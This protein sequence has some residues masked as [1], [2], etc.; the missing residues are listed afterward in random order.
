MVKKEL[1]AQ[2][3][4]DFDKFKDKILG[5]LLFGSVIT[6]T[7]TERSDV[8]VCVVVGRKNVKE[9]FD[10]LLESG[11]TGKYDIK[12]F[13]SLSLKIKGEILEN[14]VVVWAKDKGELSY[15]LHKYRKIWED[16]KLALKKIGLEIFT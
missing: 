9:I 3:N 7:E 2:I 15:Y 16:Q 4:R 1:M 8:D 10:L 14:H 12:I 6:G 11:L 5:I 13:E